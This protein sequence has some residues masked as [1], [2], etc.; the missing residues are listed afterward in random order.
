MGFEERCGLGP[1]LGLQ[2]DARGGG[3]FVLLQILP[4]APDIVQIKRPV[5][6]AAGIIAPNFALLAIPESAAM[7]R[8]VRELLP[9]AAPAT[10][11]SQRA[12]T[13]GANLLA[14]AGSFVPSVCFNSRLPIVCRSWAG[15][16]FRSRYTPVFACR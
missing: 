15:T 1:I 14:S 8:C 12:I 6:R 9:D 16:T 2:E 10:I 5:L 11:D 3:I 13:G 7:S 4:V